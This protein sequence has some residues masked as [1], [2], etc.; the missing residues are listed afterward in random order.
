MDFS[1]IETTAVVA[2]LGFGL[3]LFN[4]GYLQFYRDR[5]RISAEARFY[6]VDESSPEP[7]I[8]VTVKNRGR[9]AVSIRVKFIGNKDD[10]SGDI[11]DPPRVLG[12]G[13][14]YSYEISLMD[15]EKIGAYGKDFVP[16]DIWLED[17]LDNRIPV[18][19]ASEAM[20]AMISA[21]IEARVER[22]RRRVQLASEVLSKP[23]NT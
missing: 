12:E 23:P 21:V 3:A 18:A 2:W 4:I 10:G 6:P 5:A 7:S 1:K 16:D 11:I 14:R 9:R 20:Q 8:T 19:G 15:I 13:G 17:T 22:R